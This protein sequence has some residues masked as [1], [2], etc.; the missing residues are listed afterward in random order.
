M[1]P[2]RYGPSGSV[3]KKF[4]ENPIRASSLPTYEHTKKVWANNIFADRAIISYPQQ[5]E[6]APFSK[7]VRFFNNL[8][9]ATETDCIF[10]DENKK[11]DFCLTNLLS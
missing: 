8:N 11:S 1:H 5:P 2:S 9:I 3:E 7:T 4:K 6:E 10:I